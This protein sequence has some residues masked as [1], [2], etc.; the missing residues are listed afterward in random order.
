[1]SKQ[2]ITTRHVVDSAEEWEG[3]AELASSTLPSRA[4]LRRVQPFHPGGRIALKLFPVGGYIY[5]GRDTLTVSFS[6]KEA[7]AI[8]NVPERV[9]R[10]AIEAK[11]IQPRVVQVGRAPR[12][13]FDAHDLLYL[14]LL[15]TF[16]FPLRPDD[17]QALRDLIERKRQSSG[18]W[19]R[20]DDAAIVRS[21]DVEVRVELHQLREALANR[22]RTFHRGRRRVVSNPAVLGGEP[23]F[24]GTRIPLSHIAALVAK[25]VPVEELLEDYPALSLDDLRFAAMVARMKP[26]PGRPR[27][28]LALRRDGHPVSTD[29]RAIGARETPAR[30]GSRNGAPSTGA[31][32]R[33]ASRTS[34]YLAPTIPTSGSTRSTTIS[35]W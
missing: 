5:P 3:A 22:L 13:R 6:L 31:F 23:V 17:K 7:A 4:T 19:F 11:T 2:P 29:D 34:D 15:T 1:M 18:R 14:K 28:A 20:T 30:L 10:K 27:K 26:N 9:V 33:R 25:N 32:T 24:E 8:A 16:P 35:W 12:Y 21:G